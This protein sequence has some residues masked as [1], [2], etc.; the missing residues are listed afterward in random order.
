[1]SEFLI[2][3][4]E[5]RMELK[6]S[7]EEIIAKIKELARPLADEMGLELVDVEY[8]TG[9]DFLRVFIDRPGQRVSMEDCSG[10]SRR[11]SAVLDA[12]DPIPH[13]YNLEVSSPGLD[14]PLKKAEDFIRHAGQPVKAVI[15]QPLNGQNT[16]IGRIGDV[17][18][19]MVR[20]ILKDQESVWLPLAQIKKAR[21]EVELKKT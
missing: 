10:L 17:Q 19:G 1:M 7:A 21:L 15:G 20:I 13:P 5:H 6:S 18:N 3:K 16:F 4:A 8:K 14:R 11:I 12:D 2:L 9:G